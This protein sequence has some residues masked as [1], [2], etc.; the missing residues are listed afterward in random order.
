MR[1]LAPG[2]VIVEGG[3]LRIGHAGIPNVAYPDGPFVP[4]ETVTATITGVVARGRFAG[5][6]YLEHTGRGELLGSATVS[7]TV[8]L[9][10]LT[11]E[12]AELVFDPP[13]SIR[14]HAPTS[15]ALACERNQGKIAY[16]M[17]GV[18]ADFTGST[19]TE[20]RIDTTSDLPL[21]SVIEPEVRCPVRSDFD[22]DGYADLAIGAPG[23]RAGTVDLAGAV[24]VLYGSA[25][26]LTAD[27]DQLWTQDSRGVPGVSRTREQFGAALAAGDFDRD[28]KADLAVGAP[29]DSIDGLRSG[30]VTI[31]YGTK[32][33]LRATGSQRW[34]RAN[35]PGSPAS[36]D[37]FGAAVAAA[38][39]DGDGYDDLVVG[40]PA[41]DIA[42]DGDDLG[43]IEV[44]YGGP[45]GLEAGRATNFDRSYL[46]AT[47]R[48][49]GFFGRA[50][51]AGDLDGDGYA[52][53]AIGAPLGNTGVDDVGILYGGPLGLTTEGSQSWSQASPGVAGDTDRDDWFGAALSAGDFDLDGIDDLAIGAPGDDVLGNGRH[54]GGVTVLYGSP[55]GLIAQG[56]QWWHQNLPNFP[57]SAENYDW[58]GQAVSAGNL[59]NDGYADLAIG[60]PGD[61]VGSA[62]GAGAIFVLWGGSGGLTRFGAQRWSQASAGMPGTPEAGDRF[63]SSLAIGHFGRSAP[64]DLAIGI[65][66]EAIGARGDD[67]LIGVLYGRTNSLWSKHS[68]E[69]WQDRMGIGGSSENH[70]GLGTALTP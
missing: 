6:P 60:S 42:A 64:G 68:Q 24:N 47:E 66:G 12:F 26:G 10:W 39:F 25:A 49:S 17:V 4:G 53:I 7:A 15:A 1:V 54:Q 36:G 50:L 59:D 14:Y 55:E 32:R 16:L 33:G 23:D 35:L 56:S 58:F 62:D 8:P 63:G 21:A 9:T 28:G 22:G 44:L 43:S 46:G 18:I 29:S 27:G 2:E 31:L 3:R 41:D 69:W 61:R 20:A 57:G 11:D 38:D 19:G 40:V 45:A 51:A 34:S 37:Q 30:G 67:G 48:L 52:D 13:V 5:K 70:D 65:P